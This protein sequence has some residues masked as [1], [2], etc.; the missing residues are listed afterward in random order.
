ML[1]TKNFEHSKSFDVVVVGG[2]VAGFCAAVA[3]ARNGAKTALIEDLGALGGILT[4]GANPE[5]GIFYAYEKQAIAGIGWELCKR[6]EAK[7]FADIPDFSVVDTRKGCSPSNVKVNIAM[8]ENEMNQMCLECGV[9]LFFHT[10]IVDGIVDGGRVKS[11]IVAQKGGLACIEAGVFI[12]CTGDGDVAYLCGAEQEK[13]DVLQPGTFGYAFK[14]NN[15][16]SLDEATLRAAF[17]ERKEKGLIKEGDY[18]P[19]YHGTMKGFLREGGNNANHLEMDG[20]SAADITAAEIEGRAA[21]ARMLEFASANADVSVY[22]PADYVSPRETR[23][24][25]CDYTITKEDYLTGK[26]FPD[27][28]CYYYYNLDLHSTKKDGKRPFEL[29]EDDEKLPEGVVPTV[30]YSAMTVKGLS[31]LLTAGRCISAERIVMGALRV[32][33]PCMA[34]GQAVGTAAALCRGA[35]VRNVDMT[36]LKSTLKNQGAIVPDK[37]LFSVAE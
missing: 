36:L 7:G 6:L 19:E 30:P 27:S 8:A 34:M 37:T 11:I 3:S 24:T 32:K 9:T 18:W 2:G 14:C 31:N 20:S 28:L 13:S 23:R 21:M 33:A 5:I 10:K 25:V 17:Q 15:L 4:T 1:Y 22:P 12:D 29:D 26:I 35:E 16:D